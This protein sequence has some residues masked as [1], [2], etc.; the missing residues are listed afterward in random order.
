MNARLRWWLHEWDWRPLARLI[1]WSAVAIAAVRRSGCALPD[2]RA[3]VREWAL[4]FLITGG[5]MTYAQLWILA[6]LFRLYLWLDDWTYA[7]AERLV[8]PAAGR[9]PFAANFL[10]ALAVQLGLVL[11]GAAYWRSAHLGPRLLTLA[12]GGF[13]ALLRAVA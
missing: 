6:M 11:A 3:V 9:A 2:P 10:A 13:R 1:V 12:E 7:L 5:L 8:Q 4:A